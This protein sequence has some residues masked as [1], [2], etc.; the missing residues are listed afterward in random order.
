MRKRWCNII[1]G[2]LGS[3]ALAPILIMLL[4]RREPL[5][6][7]DGHIAP[8]NV[9]VGDDVLITFT[10]R[11]LRNCDGRLHKRFFDSAGI[12]HASVPEP[13]IYHQAIRDKRT[14]QKVA[15]IPKGM[16]SGPAIYAPTIER[17]CNP[18]QRMLWP[19][20]GASLRLN[21]NVVE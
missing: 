21:F 4:D 12:I 16:A 19:I 1:G 9:H 7:I 17:W 8:Y 20:N 14:F 18:L 6:L 15:T 13:T 2:V 5:E 11:E 10:V 3:L